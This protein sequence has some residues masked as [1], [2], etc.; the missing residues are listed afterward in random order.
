MQQRACFYLAST[1]CVDAIDHLSTV[2]L[3]L[4]QHLRLQPHVRVEKRGL[5]TLG[6]ALLSRLLEQQIK[7]LLHLRVRLGRHQLAA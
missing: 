5:A 4:P 6:L 2:P 3:A 1:I 7:E